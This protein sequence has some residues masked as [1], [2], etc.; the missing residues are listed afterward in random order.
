MKFGQQAEL[1][2]QKLPLTEIYLKL[3]LDLGMKLG[4]QAEL[5]RDSTRNSSADQMNNE[6]PEGFGIR[7]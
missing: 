3:G 7:A 5:N 1:S 6:K 2:I 4:Q